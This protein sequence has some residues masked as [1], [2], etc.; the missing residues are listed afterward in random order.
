MGNTERQQSL[1]QRNLDFEHSTQLRELTG[2]CGCH[3]KQVGRELGVRITQRGTTLTVSGDDGSVDLAASLLNQLYVLINGGLTLSVPL[4][5][6]A[7]RLI[8]LDPEARLADFFNDVVFVGRK[9]RAI[10]PRSLNQRIYVETIRRSDIV[11]GLGPAGTGKTYLAVAMAVAALSANDVQRIVLCRPAVEAGEKL[12]FL[13]GDLVEKVNPYLRPLYDA[14]HEMIGYDKTL[15]L[16]E[17]GVIEVAPLAFMRGRTLSE[18][19]VIL[20]EAQNTT[21][22]QMKMFLTRLG[23]GSRAV[24]TGDPSQVDLPGNTRSG[25]EEASRILRNIPRIGFVEFTADDVARHALVS[26]IIRA[27]DEARS[28]GG[29]S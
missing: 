25:L 8:R 21:T 17:R 24:V 19:F 11:F 2:D 13:P 29:E 1:Q 6:H 23:V 9:K 27:Y 20:D 22:E 18:A 16:M 14:L 5:G 26:A 7:C 10:F 12:G 3:L 28:G 4:V 15:R